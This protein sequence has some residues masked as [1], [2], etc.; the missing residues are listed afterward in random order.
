MDVLDVIGEV[1]GPAKL[2]DVRYYA[3]I[4]ALLKEVR[5]FCKEPSESVALRV[6]CRG[7]RDALVDVDRLE[8]RQDRYRTDP[9]V[10]P[11]VDER[12]RK[13]G[14]T[15]LTTL[16]KMKKPSAKSRSRDAKM[17]MNGKT[18]KKK[19]TKKTKKGKRTS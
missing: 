8:R 17:R 13:E 6:A 18:K 9:E 2:V 10:S 4:E 5:S 11:L 7:M 15:G 12:L 16:K 3:A 14:P 1:R 19:K